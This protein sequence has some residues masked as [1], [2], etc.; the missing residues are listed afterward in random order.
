VSGVTV[1]VPEELVD[2]IGVDVELLPEND[3]V[4]V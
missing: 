1:N 3:A 2:P 4:S